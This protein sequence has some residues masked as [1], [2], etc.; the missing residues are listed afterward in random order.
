MQIVKSLDVGHCDQNE[1]FLAIHTT[2]YILG[3]IPRIVGWIEGR[4][5]PD[6]RSRRCLGL[7]MVPMVPRVCLRS[8]P[9]VRASDSYVARARTIIAGKN[10]FPLR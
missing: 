2:L 3:I 1:Q 4:K 7:K 6:S 9:Q 8:T 5:V 10:R